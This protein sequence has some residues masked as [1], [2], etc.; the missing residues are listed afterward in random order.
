MYVYIL[1][2]GVEEEEERWERVRDLFLGWAFSLSLENFAVEEGNGVETHPGIPPLSMWFARVT[3]LLQTS[4]CH[5]LRPRT[6]QWTLPVCIPTLMFTFTAPT[7]RYNLATSNKCINYRLEERLQQNEELPRVYIY[8]YILQKISATSK[9]TVFFFFF[10]FFCEKK[11]SISI[12][13][14]I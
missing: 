3:S 9:H 4:N 5:F 8:I 11:Y 1:K 2:W 7:S 12:R 10:F 13:L 6:P 14:K